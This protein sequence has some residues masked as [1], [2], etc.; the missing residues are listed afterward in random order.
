MAK[1]QPLMFKQVVG[2]TN[3][4]LQAKAGES[5]LIKDILIQTPVSSYATLWVDKDTVGYFRVGGNAGNHL[6]L[7]KGSANHAHSL[8]VAAADGALAQDHAL[9]DAH[10]ISNAHIAVFS[11][12]AALTTETD[13]VQYGAIPNCNY[14]SLLGHLNKSGIFKGYPVGE[15]ETFLITGVAQA[16]SIQIVIYEVY[17]AADMPSTVENGGK[18]NKYMFVNYGRQ[19][20]ALVAAGDGLYSV[21]Q[22]PAQF[23]NFPYGE[24]VPAKH[25]ITIHGILISDIVD[26]RSAADYM[27]TRYIKLLRGRETLFDDDKNGILL[28]GLIGTVNAAAEIARGVSLIGNL[29]DLDIKPPFMFPVPLEFSEGEELN[30]YLTVAAGAAVAA[31]TIP[32]VESEIGL[33]MTVEKL[34]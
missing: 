7:L 33:I 3:L 25:K 8:I 24:K 17:D 11:D 23:P 20:A 30:V 16:T 5:L 2:N 28:Y 9:S 15:G 21:S 32:V 18:A 6:P 4:S 22:T 29:T 19:A 14:Q 27:A 10:G 34:G 13:I 26:Y 12:R 31:S 1:R